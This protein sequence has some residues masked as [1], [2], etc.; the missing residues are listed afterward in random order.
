MIRPFRF[1]DAA[2]VARLQRAGV[3]LDLE[4]YL[5]RSHSPLG[6]AI[7]SHLFP[8]RHRAC[9]CIADHREEDGGC[10]G[11]AQMRQRPE[12]KEYVVAFIAPALSAGG[13]VHATWQRLLAH[14][15]VKAGERG[16]QRLYAGLPGEG[17]E[18]QIFRH[19][20]FTAYA[21]EDVYQCCHR[22]PLPQVAQLPRRQ[23][24]RD[25]WGLQK[26]Y[27]AVTPRAVQAA[28]GS[29]HGEWELAPYHW[30]ANPQQRGYVWETSGEVS[31]ALQVRSTADAHWLRLLLHP[32]MLDQATAVVAA[33]MASIGRPSRQKIFW[34]VRTYEAG[35]QA[36]LAEFGFEPVASQTLVVKHCTIWAREPA[37]KPVHALNGKA[38]PAAPTIKYND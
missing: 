18:Y 2:L 10:L 1:W 28:Q 34:A 6:T 12:R 4:T 3:A 5:T 17:E 38:E 36:A 13:G 8:A 22:L 29:G 16:G 30:P 32:D 33:A 9:T 25:G 23:R 27:G 26:L 37:L 21:Q 7:T 24:E 14:L 11:L 31:A 35:M 19:V 20:G 15:A